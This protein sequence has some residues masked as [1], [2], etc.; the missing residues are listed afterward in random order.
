MV[1][2]RMV[3]IRNT[4]LGIGPASVRSFA[5]KCEGHHAR[6]VEL[7]CNVGHVQS[8]KTGNYTGLVCK[9]ADAGYKIIIVLAGLHN[10]LRSQTQ[11]RA[12][13]GR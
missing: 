3:H 13:T 4:N 2:E 1:R 10:N 9:A 12:K 11:M 8:G 6:Q 5:A 7:A